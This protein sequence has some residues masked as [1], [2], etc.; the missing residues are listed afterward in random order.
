MQY[1]YFENGTLLV[2][3]CLFCV[4][5]YFTGDSR[6]GSPDKDIPKIGVNDR[7]SVFLELADAY[8]HLGQKVT[9]FRQVKNIVNM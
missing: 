4:Q 5:F 8:R 3:S 1:K 6:Q 9:V 2:K 7:V